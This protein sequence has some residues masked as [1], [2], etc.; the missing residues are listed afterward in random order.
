MDALIDEGAVTQDE[1]ARQAIYTQ[2]QQMISE[3]GAV[4]IPYFR[5]DI[6]AVH[7][8]VQNMAAD[9]IPSFHQVWLA[10]E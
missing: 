5:A 2:V 3:E 8:S 1:A 4:L 10:Q 7:S 6:K 9:V